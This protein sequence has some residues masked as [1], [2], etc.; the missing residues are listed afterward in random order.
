MHSLVSFG[1]SPRIMIIGVAHNN[2]RNEEEILDRVDAPV[3][4]VCHERSED[5]TLGN[6]LKWAATSPLIAI[7]ILLNEFSKPEFDSECEKAAYELAERDDAGDV[8]HIGMNY[9]DRI[10]E[11]PTKEMIFEWGLIM[12]VLAAVL[13]LII[14]PVST[15]WILLTALVILLVPITGRHLERWEHP[16]RDGA[17]ADNIMKAI[18]E[19][20]CGTIAVVVGEDH[21]TGI[22]GRLQAQGFPVEAIWLNTILKNEKP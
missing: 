21:V 16:R 22:G 12:A 5:G 20:S 11:K 9:S 7:S 8:A 1:M 4:K 18:P 17:M 10:A 13:K 14:R 19:P 6:W 3:E 15:N 2:P